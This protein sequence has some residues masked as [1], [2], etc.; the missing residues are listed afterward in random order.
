[1]VS[2]RLTFDLA[3]EAYWARLVALDRSMRRRKNGNASLL[4][5]YEETNKWKN[6]KKKNEHKK[7]KNTTIVHCNIS[8][9]LWNQSRFI[10]QKKDSKV[11]LYCYEQWQ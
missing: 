7:K 3:F 9:S 11:G 1:M 10:S 4:Y 5:N 2:F 8:N 6:H